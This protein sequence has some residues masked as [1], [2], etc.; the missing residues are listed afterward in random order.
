MSAIATT[1]LFV[2]IV[3]APWCKRCAEIKP[4]VVQLCKIAGATLEEVNYDELEETDSLKLSVTALPTVRLLVEQ[5]GR[6][7][8]WKSYTPKELAAWEDQ[9]RLYAVAAPSSEDMDF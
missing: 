6:S 1:R 9:M 7:S 4:Q 5:A 3:S 8:G 2:Q